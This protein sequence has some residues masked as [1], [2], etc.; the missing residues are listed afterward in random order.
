MRKAADI[1]GVSMDMSN[2]INVH[3]AA[4]KPAHPTLFPLPADTNAEEYISR[5]A[6]R[7]SQTDYFAKRGFSNETVKRFRLGFDPDFREG[8]GKYPWKAVIIPTSSSSYEGRNISVAPNSKEGAGFKCRKHGRTVI[9]NG[10]C[11]A[12]EKERPIFITEGC[13]D[14]LSIIECGG[15]AAAVGGV[16]NTGLL[17]TLL[18]KITPSVPLMLA[19]DNDDAGRAASDKLAKELESRGSALYKRFR[20]VDVAVS[21]PER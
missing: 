5:C 17:S 21:R 9:F 4:S 20:R 6:E 10:S 2:H 13:F 7:V 3:S 15:Q 11:F 18:D 12:E 16:S 1:Y 14:A 8:T 19:F